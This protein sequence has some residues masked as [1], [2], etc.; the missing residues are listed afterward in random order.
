VGDHPLLDVYGAKAVGARAILFTKYAENF[1]KY[2]S[3]YYSANGRHRTPDCAVDELSE[4]GA[5]LARLS[6]R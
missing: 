6:R 1:E 2:A 4:V 5:A 3:Q